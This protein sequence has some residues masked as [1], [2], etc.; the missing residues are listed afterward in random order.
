MGLWQKKD[1]RQDVSL[2]NNYSDLPVSTEGCDTLVVVIAHGFLAENKKEKKVWFAFRMA[3]REAPRITRWKTALR[4]GCFLYLPWSEYQ[5]QTVDCSFAVRKVFLYIPTERN[6]VYA[7]DEVGWLRS[8]SAEG[9]Y[10]YAARWIC[11]QA[12]DMEGRYER[13]S[14]F[15]P[16][17]HYMSEPIKAR[18]LDRFY[19]LLHAQQLL[20]RI[21][22][23][24]N[25]RNPAHR[26]LTEAIQMSMDRNDPVQ[27]VYVL[28]KLCEYCIHLSAVKTI[29]GKSF[30]K[31]ELLEKLKFPSFGTLS[32]I[33]AGKKEIFQDRELTVKARTLETL[34]QNNGKHMIRESRVTYAQVC[35]L[36]V[37]IRNHFLGHGILSEDD[38]VKM[39]AP[40]AAMTFRI[41]SH[42]A[43]ADYP[44][45]NDLIPSPVQ[46]TSVPAV[47][48]KDKE[49]FYFAGFFPSGDLWF[50]DYVCFRQGFELRFSLDDLKTPVW[51]PVKTASENP[52]IQIPM[53][54]GYM[55]KDLTS[56]QL[57]AISRF[58]AL[59]LGKTLL[60]LRPGKNPEKLSRW[61]NMYSGLTLRAFE[62][63]EPEYFG[64]AADFRDLHE[65]LLWMKCPVYFYMVD[66][67]VWNNF[68]KGKDSPERYMFGELMEMGRL[69]PVC[70]FVIA[71][72]GM[73][74]EKI[75]NPYPWIRNCDVL[76]F[77]TEEDFAGWKAAYTIN[78]FDVRMKY[79]AA[80]VNKNRKIPEH[81][82][83]SEGMQVY[84]ERS[85][86]YARLLRQFDMPSLL[87]NSD[88]PWFAGLLKNAMDI[89]EY[90]ASIV[91]LL[92]FA[93]STS[94]S[95]LYG[96][97][98]K[99]NAS[100]IKP[101]GPWHDNI[102]EIGAAVLEI[103]EGKEDERFKDLRSR[104]LRVSKRQKELQERCRK[105]FPVS[106]EGKEIDFE[107]TFVILRYLR[108]RTKGHGVVQ[109]G[110]GADLW[111]LTF[112]Y[113]MALVRF[114][115]VYDFMFIIKDGKIWIHF[116]GEPN[117][118]HRSD[119]FILENGLPCPR[120]NDYRGR[121]SYMNYFEGHRIVA[122]RKEKDGI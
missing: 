85:E 107:M 1:K 109:P 39:A 5:K 97:C 33:Q 91:S 117:D 122:E 120:W 43:A 78:F 55:T 12:D 52:G 6:P 37:R 49:Y 58:E 88:N 57:K 28:L 63:Y 76:A 112:T 26:Y 9:A 60:E 19:D 77:K 22:Q 21:F 65:S 45:E 64:D 38:A 24:L 104:R 10:I 66:R 99:Y 59:N 16:L 46:G 50:A 71:V 80:L 44:G 56:K 114:L 30:E 62:L 87:M 100:F 15:L 119:L 42:F 86:I 94:L 121:I 102:A 14:F 36:V 92:N 23:Q 93:E 118:Y 83:I 35:E 82:L 67:Y 3:F 31:E 13:N 29:S 34:I 11:F 95:V 110:T 47:Y 51:I 32:Q 101:G 41:V 116:R 113:V 90:E 81:M 20:L 8:R 70:H 48:I 75:V 106:L 98:S 2:F 18:D 103:A 115:E 4:V 27:K 79:S 25:Y 111:E 61:E 96:L 108:N 68:V 73:E 72:I 53:R 89:R 54:K 74:P 105:Y 40:L 69:L 7:D 17:P 84:S